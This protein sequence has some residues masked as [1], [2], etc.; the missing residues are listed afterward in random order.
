[1]GLRGVDFGVEFFRF[2][3]NL[4]DSLLL[5]K[6]LSS[7][8]RSAAW[9]ICVNFGGEILP[10]LPGL[11]ASVL[12]GSAARQRTYRCETGVGD[13]AMVIL[14]GGRTFFY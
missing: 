12:D 11:L 8:G 5:L 13:V 9:F 10:S 6:P 7:C 14:V 4:V 2:L 1:M 3:P